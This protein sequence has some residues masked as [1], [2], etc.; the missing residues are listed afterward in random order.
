MTVGGKVDLTGKQLTIKAMDLESVGTLLSAEHGIKV[1]VRGVTI[2]ITVY[3]E[4]NVRV[5]IMP[6]ELGAH[7]K[8]H[9]SHM[10]EGQFYHEFRA[11]RR[12]KSKK[13]V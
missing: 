8:N 10:N 3:G 11:L 1:E 9:H 7:L 4:K 6:K 12:K 13:K 2:D 5:S